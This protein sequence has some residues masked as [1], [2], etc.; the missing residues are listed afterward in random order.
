MK[1]ISVKDEMPNDE[2]SFLVYCVYHACKE[3][4]VA[5]LGDDDRFLDEKYNTPLPVT[6]WMSLPEP[7]KE[8]S[9]YD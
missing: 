4:D 8:P 1:W 5:Y 2:R 3:C 6:H 9:E 7:P